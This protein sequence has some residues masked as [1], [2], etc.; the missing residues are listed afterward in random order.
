MNTN[1]IEAQLCEARELLRNT[2]RLIAADFASATGKHGFACSKAYKE[3]LANVNTA[4]E[5]L[6]YPIHFYEDNEGEEDMSKT[7]IKVKLIGEDGNIFNLISICCIALRRNGMRDKEE[8]FLKEVKSG[9]YL[10]ALVVM[11][12]WFDIH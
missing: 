11:N 5:K 10:H 8:Q 2:A 1:E 12:E 4:I 3:L 6:N 7:G 9:D